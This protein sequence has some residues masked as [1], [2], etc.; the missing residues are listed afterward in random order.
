MRAAGINCPVAELDLAQKG[1][2][3]EPEEG[4]AARPEGVLQGARH[5]HSPQLQ[6]SQVGQGDIQLSDL[7]QGERKE[8][9]GQISFKLI[10]LACSVAWL[11]HF[12]LGPCA[13]REAMAL[14]ADTGLLI[15]QH[16]NKPIH[17]LSA[18]VNEGGRDQVPHLLTHDGRVLV[19]QA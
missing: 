12:C 14:I 5:H 10:I 6:F 1:G 2:G 16:W 18:T 19:E 7:L 11:N 9:Y 8:G 4:G 15:M 13:V 3:C 17:K